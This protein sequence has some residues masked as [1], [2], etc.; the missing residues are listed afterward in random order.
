[1]QI[2]FVSLLFFAFLQFPD[3]CHGF[4]PAR[5]AICNFF[6]VAKPLSL[7]K[8]P[9]F[10]TSEHVEMPRWSYSNHERSVIMGLRWWPV[11]CIFLSDKKRASASYL[12]LKYV[13]LAAWKRWMVRPVFGKLSSPQVTSTNF[14]WS[15]NQATRW[16]P[17]MRNGTSPLFA[18]CG[19]DR[20]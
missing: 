20:P 17:Q 12:T 11:D 8:P 1:M 14:E 9:M 13:M 3:A 7:S 6:T 18:I 4:S 5:Y 15:W 16:E 19:N 2:R 10:Y